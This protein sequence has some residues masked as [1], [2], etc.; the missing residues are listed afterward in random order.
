MGSSFID[1]RLCS[2]HSKV[3]M[4]AWK[5][6]LLCLNLLTVVGT[7]ATISTC[8]GPRVPE[9]ISGVHGQLVSANFKDP[10]KLVSYLKFCLYLVFDVQRR[11]LEIPR[12]LAL[13]QSIKTLKTQ[14][15]NLPSAPTMRDAVG[16]N[17]CSVTVFSMLKASLF[18]MVV[19]P[20]M[21]RRPPW[22]IVRLLST[23]MIVVVCLILNSKG[24]RG[25]V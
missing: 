6:V 2:L 1:I 22:I 19:L 10:L 12:W 8:R 18:V 25:I 21:W 15:T 9:G 13:N 24:V 16:D 5:H 11:D 23:R 7:D 20:S 17:C 14:E 4:S 3:W